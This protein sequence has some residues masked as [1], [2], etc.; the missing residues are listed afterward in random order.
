M[1]YNKSP[2]NGGTICREVYPKNNPSPTACGF[3]PLA[4]KDGLLILSGYWTMRLAHNHLL[5]VLDNYAASSVGHKLA[6]QV[7]SLF[8]VCLR[9]QLG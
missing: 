9:S 7:E 4:M 3:P 8:V 5:A 2:R 1:T 6:I